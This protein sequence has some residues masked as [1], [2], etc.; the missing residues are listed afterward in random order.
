MLK[1]GMSR[2]RLSFI[3]AAQELL[4]VTQPYADAMVCLCFLSKSLQRQRAGYP[5]VCNLEGAFPFTEPTSHARK[6]EAS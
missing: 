3:Y 2:M 1:F 4:G 5:K 6:A